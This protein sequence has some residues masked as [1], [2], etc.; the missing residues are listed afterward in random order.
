MAQFKLENLLALEALAKSHDLSLNKPE[1]HTNLLKIIERRFESF[2]NPGIELFGLRTQLMFAFIVNSLRST[3]AI[4]EEDSGLFFSVHEDISRPDFRIKTADREFLVE[5]KNLNQK[6]YAE[7]FVIAKDYLDKKRKYAEMF[8]LPLFFAVYWSRMKAWTLLSEETFSGTDE[9]FEL[10]FPMAIMKNQ[11][12][13]LGDAMLGLIPPIGLRLY[14]DQ[15]RTSEIDDDGNSN[16]VVEA[17]KMFSGTTELKDQKSG[18]VLWHLLQYGDWSEYSQPAKIKEN[19]LVE[20]MFES[21][22]LERANPDQDFEII[23]ALSSIL[24]RQ[25][26]DLT[27]ENNTNELISVTPSHALYNLGGAVNE[28]MKIGELKVWKFI[29]RPSP[30]N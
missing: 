24:S 9:K 27:T 15:D 28:V 30:D 22:P 10:P 11:M 17:A 5:V 20:M 23:G 25:Y 2:A 8:G 6:N 18:E 16:V 14:F 19:K 12:N 29:L 7:P 4:N 21:H 13:V 3:I 26:N 1:D